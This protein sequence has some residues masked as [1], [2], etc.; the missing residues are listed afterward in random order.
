MWQQ[1]GKRAYGDP[2]MAYMSTN[3]SFAYLVGY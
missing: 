3:L 1:A 2:L